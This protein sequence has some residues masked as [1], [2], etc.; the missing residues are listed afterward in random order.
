MMLQSAEPVQEWDADQ[1]TCL[2]ACVMKPEHQEW[3]PGN[4]ET[5]ERPIL[6]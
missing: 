2:R 1:I 5:V 4:F 3:L 6:T